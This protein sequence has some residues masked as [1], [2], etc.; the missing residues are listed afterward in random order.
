[1]TTVIDSLDKRIK[2]YYGSLRSYDFT[3]LSKHQHVINLLN[4][5]GFVFSLVSHNIPQGPRQIRVIGSLTAA[6]VFP[7][8]IPK[9]FDCTLCIPSIYQIEEPL[10][11]AWNR[12]NQFV[13]QPDNIY[14][15]TAEQYL[16][17]GI[18]HLLS[19]LDKGEIPNPSKLIGLGHGLTPDGDDFL[20]GL[21]ISTALPISPFVHQR[22]TL[23]QAVQQQIH[24]THQ[25]SAAFIEDA[26]QLQVSTPIQNFI[27]CLSTPQIANHA[28]DDIIHIG[29]RSGTSILSGLLAGLP[30]SKTRR[31]QLCPY[32]V[33]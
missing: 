30:H 7:A 25:I 18:S 32:I 15:Q 23:V 16:Q 4:Q 6:L 21:L 17:I 3:V 26:C 8:M 28:I 11:K 33:N 9:L 12:L 13:H 19:S 5:E 24:R 20:C 10:H 1:M 22:H 29:H 27:N 31:T 2:P 14:S